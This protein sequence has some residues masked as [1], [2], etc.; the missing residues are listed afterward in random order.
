MKPTLLLLF[1]LLQSVIFGQINGVVT[2]P[3]CHDSMDG[4]IDI[5]FDGGSPPYTYTWSNGAITEDVENLAS[6][7]YSLTITDSSGDIYNGEWE[8]IF[9][10]PI[11]VDLIGEEP[12]CY[13]EDG[14]LDVFAWGGTEEFTYLWS[15]PGV[16]GSTEMSLTNLQEGFY[17][18]TATDSNGCSEST[19]IFINVPDEIIVESFV[20]D[21]AC[22]GTQISLGSIEINVEGGLPPYSYFW[23]GPVSDDSAKDQYDLN[24]GDYTLYIDDSNGCFAEQNFTINGET[25]IDISA[26]G[27]TITCVNGETILGTIDVE[28]TGGVPPYSFTWTGEGVDPNTQNQDGLLEGEYSVTVTDSE[29]CQFQEFNIEIINEAISA[30][31]LCLITNDNPDGY[32]TL[33]WEAPVDDSD[34]VYYNTYREGNAAGQFEIIGSVDFN[35]DNEFFD[36]EAN[37]LVQ[38]YRYYV[39]AVNACG[40]ESD[41]SEIHK[42]IHLTISIGSFGSMNLI[43]DEY[44]GVTYDQVVIYSGENPDA[45]E[46][47][48]SLPGN[49]FSYT[50]PNPPSGDV[51]YQ[52]VVSTVVNCEIQEEQLQKLIFEL[53]SNI[54]G[55]VTSNVENVKWLN[56]VYPNPFEDEITIDIEQPANTQ[57][58]DVNGRVLKEFLLPAGKNILDMSQLSNGLYMIK[59][60]SGNENT[61]WR[62]IKSR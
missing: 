42:T 22:V 44:E 7:F 61:V 59:L 50:I 16:D 43:W 26:I 49:L 36:T 57:V 4:A 33:Y 31:S 20:M 6:A 53:K 15:G 3:S 62:G 2:D 51:Y 52:I 21:V 12:F 37:S 40:F 60:I 29:E 55:F 34:I 47:L 46:E 48:V 39:T 14:F 18:V 25:P 19:E 41:P 38:A 24:A 30:P 56:E 23:S 27:S 45:L 1:T 58:L 9:L 11:F 10:E 32:N 8:L 5:T 35:S 17:Y 13:E 54:A 28:V